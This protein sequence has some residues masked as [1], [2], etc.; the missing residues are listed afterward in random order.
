MSLRHSQ[1]GH[2]EQIF[3]HRLV[4]TLRMSSLKVPL[5]LKKKRETGKV[6]S[7]SSPSAHLLP[8]FQAADYFLASFSFFSLAQFSSPVCVHA[9]SVALFAFTAPILL[10]HALFPQV[11]R[12]LSNKGFICIPSPNLLPCFILI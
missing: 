3:P 6:A 8:V 5:Y 10:F 4:S 12:D 2:L 9:I 7:P 11:N 1:N